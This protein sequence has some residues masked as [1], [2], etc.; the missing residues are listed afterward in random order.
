MV[1]FPSL[2]KIAI[3]PIKHVIEINKTGNDKSI[4]SGAEGK[5]LEVISSALRFQHDIVISPDG[6]LGRLNKSGNWTGIIGLI[7]RDQA[8]L[9]LSFLAITEKRQEVVDFTSSYTIQGVTFLVEKPG[10]IRGA[11]TFIYPFDAITW[12]STAAILV[13]LPFIFAFF[14]NIRIN[15]L[16]LLIDL[17]GSLLRQ[18]LEI[19]DNSLKSKFLV[20]SWLIFSMIISFGY[21]ACLLSFITLPLHEQPIRNFLELSNAVKKGTHKCL[22][23]KGIST[24]SFLINAEEEYLRFLGQS[25]EENEWYYE[26]SDTLNEKI[27]TKNTAVSNIQFNLQMLNAKLTSDSYLL[28][29]D[30]LVSW[31]IGIAVRKSFCCKRALDT[32]IGRIS[33]AGLVEKFQREEL[34]NIRRTSLLNEASIETEKQ[35]TLDDLSGA[36]IIIAA[37]LTLSLFVFLSE[38]LYYRINTVGKIL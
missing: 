15:I 34:Q 3:L 7:Q 33:N 30:V 23:L 35:I 4:F 17:F 16:K 14:P 20:I 5:L 28:S 29:D 24:I 36:L 9:G 11:G 27:I 38:I 31:K 32:V 25:V 19:K 8:D 10:T 26:A 13:C 18:P 12:V 6:E 2:V 1:R 22:M 37:G 21:S